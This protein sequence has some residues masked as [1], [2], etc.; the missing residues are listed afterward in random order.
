MTNNRYVILEEFYS[1]F[2]SLS[3][4]F[5][6]IGEFSYLPVV[7]FNRQRGQAALRVAGEIPYIYVELTWGEFITGVLILYLSMD[8]RR[9][10]QFGETG[11]NSAIV[12]V[13]HIKR[14]VIWHCIV[15]KF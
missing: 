4:W 15:A 14:C 5:H 11:A 6:Y 7:H 2:I 12:F 8:L 13:R 10:C 3:L 1:L 9:L